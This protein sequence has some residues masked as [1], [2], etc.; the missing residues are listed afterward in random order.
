[1]VLAVFLG[2]LEAGL[3]L[4]PGLL[5]AARQGAPLAEGERELR[6]LGDSVTYG[7]G[8]RRDDT[9]PAALQR[10]LVEA[11]QASP[12][13]GW[14]VVNR[15]SG[16]LKIDALTR[17]ELPLLQA[18]KPEDRPLVLLLI[19]HNDLLA[20]GGQPGLP[21]SGIRPGEPPA[22]RA[23]RLLRVLRWA[24]HQREAPVSALQDLD[25]A[26]PPFEEA[27]AQLAQA[28]EAAGGRLVMM[29][30]LIPGPAPDG[31]SAEFTT[32]LA[33]SR[34]HQQ[35]INALIRAAAARLALPL[36]DLERDLPAPARWDPT[37]FLD[38]IHPTPTGYQAMAAAIGEGLRWSG[39]LADGDA[40]RP[41]N[42][43]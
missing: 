36:I 2:L 1:M 32:A 17:R 7:H 24:L 43:I 20:W 31:T 33:N 23:P 12:G 34:E 9:W 27:V 30:Y 42:G 22:A 39:L 28:T 4:L 35:R 5:L 37:W 19:G 38:D 11:G 15:G 40:T 13:R 10:W 29:T 21:P 18:M 26:L 3:G 25:A 6:C 8:V 14:R 16:G 41:Q